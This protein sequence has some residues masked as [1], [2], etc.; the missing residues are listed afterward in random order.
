MFVIDVKAFF[1]NVIS[2]YIQIFVIHVKQMEKEN[3]FGIVFH[4]M[5]FIRFTTSTVDFPLKE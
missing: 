3:T 4:F 2:E 1:V 5:I